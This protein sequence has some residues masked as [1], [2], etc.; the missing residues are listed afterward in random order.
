[1][2]HV[3][4]NVDTHA[5]RCV[6]GAFAASY[7]AGWPLSGEPDAAMPPDAAT[8]QAGGDAAIWYTPAM[9]SRVLP[10][11]DL[12]YVCYAD[13]N[14]ACL[15]QAAAPANSCVY[16]LILPADQL[17]MPLGF[18]AE[19]DGG[20]PLVWGYSSSGTSTVECCPVVPDIKTGR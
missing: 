1:M 4:I 15:K 16:S 14:K 9:G 6:R 17:S 3:G 2:E 7:D 18:V 8:W 19:P 11:A 10:R 20:Q 12:S 5:G 13:S